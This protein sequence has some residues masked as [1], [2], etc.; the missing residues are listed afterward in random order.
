VHSAFITLRFRRASNVLRRPSTRL[1]SFLKRGAHAERRSERRERLS[2]R[3]SRVISGPSDSVS[4]FSEA[5]E[6]HQWPHVLG[7]V[8]ETH[9]AMYEGLDETV[10][11][12]SDLQL[13]DRDRDCGGS[14]RT[15]Q[16]A[17][18]RTRRGRGGCMHA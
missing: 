6:G 1:T 13:R 8:G 2:Q 10:E 7:L 5:I 3:P 17:W 14:R 12:Q 15:G 11:M 4:S 16:R 18:G 9:L